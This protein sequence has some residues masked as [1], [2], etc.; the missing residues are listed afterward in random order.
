MATNP[1]WFVQQRARG[2]CYVCQRAMDDTDPRLVHL[3]CARLLN[4]G[5]RVSDVR[6][7]P[8]TIGPV[9][10]HRALRRPLRRRRVQGAA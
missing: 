3:E 10:P 1:Q 7:H 8:P 2:I 5:W 4:R 6:A 9:Q